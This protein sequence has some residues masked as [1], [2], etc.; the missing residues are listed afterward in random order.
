MRDHH[1]LKQAEEKQLIAAIAFESQEG[2]MIT[3]AS[4]IILHVNKSFTETT[5]YTIEEV[6]GKTAALLKSGRHNIDF[7]H[8]MWETINR[9]GGWQ[10]EIWDR[11]KNGE[12]YPK[13]L[14]I[15]AIKNKEGV[16]T[17]YLGT[18]FDIT[19]RKAAE[20][21]IKN[22]AFF[23]QLTGLPNRILLLD[24]LRQAMSASS[25]NGRY[26]VLMQLNLDNFALVNVTQGPDI[27]DM[28]L[29]QVAQRLTRCTHECDTVAR[30]NGDEFVVMLT[31]LSTNEIDAAKISEEVA[32]KILALLSV[33]YQLGDET[34]RSTGSIGV[35]LFRGH[36]ATIADLIKQA[37][38]AMHKAKEAGRNACRFF[39]PQMESLVIERAAL[40]KDLHQAIVEKQF[41][42]HYQPQV[43]DDGHLT[44]AEALVRWEHPQRGMVSPADFIPMAEETGLILPLGKWIME[45]A[46]AQLVLWASH[47][48]MKH[49]TL[50]VNVS[51]RQ[52]HHAS[53]ADQVLA[54]LQSTG[55]DPQR[56][57][58]E[59]TEGMMVEDI[60]DVIEKMLVL[61]TR[62][63]AFSLDD[64]GTGFSSLTYLKRLPL[65][66]LKI[67]QSFVRNVLTDANDAGITRAVVALA[68]SLGLDVIA[69]GV[70]TEAQRNFLA[71][72]GC[73]AYQGYL[74]SRPLSKENFE[75]FAQQ[76]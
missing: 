37:D 63:I 60:E 59:L 74:F 31:G 20:E 26:G 11:R 73:R 51:A 5:G 46:C 57:K 71:E 72:I 22:L 12:E 10:G 13:L 65:D 41:L 75:V 2:M 52:F 61:K 7:Y 19:E 44:G 62:G 17:H 64:F 55:V 33:P 16:T 9:T 76:F 4:G 66:Q 54:I 40:E 36:L 32:S 42:L 27:G 47:P 25:R 48:K 18:H 38:L 14:T 56:L 3:D 34:Y 70:E 69:E 35:T 58:L 68:Q 15:S 50:A 23:D 24:R 45:T 67:D 8:D 39:D 43:G 21:K 6:K 1:N 29:S 53:F 49:L 28:L 30:I